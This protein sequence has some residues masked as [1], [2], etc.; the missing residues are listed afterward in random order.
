MKI[1]KKPLGKE[2]P[3]SP[4]KSVCFSLP[5]GEAKQVCVA[6]TFNNWNAKSHPM[7]FDGK[8]RWVTEIPLP[9]G[10][11]EYQFLVDGQW[12]PD[13]QAQESVPN[14]FGSVNSVLHVTADS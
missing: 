10:T 1:A 8:Q 9:P 12:T 14:P 5:G 4:P 11:Y 6:G 2:R 3:P 7:R 13:P